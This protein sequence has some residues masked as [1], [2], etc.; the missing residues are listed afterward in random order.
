MT[1]LLGFSLILTAALVCSAQRIRDWKA[2]SAALEAFCEMLSQLRGILEVQAPPMPELLDALSRCSGGAAERFVKQLCQAM[3]RL[4]A[5]SFQTLWLEALADTAKD[6]G[7]DARHALET[8][9][10]VLGRYDL[11]TQLSA[12][13]ACLRVL[14]RQ[15]EQLREKAPQ[16]GRLTLGIMLSAA[17]LLGILLM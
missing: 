3:D 15:Q 10:S 4:G 8:L 16:S 5:V 11:D 17:A 9:G 6:V 12:V 14:R 7:E 1:K 2:R 13:D